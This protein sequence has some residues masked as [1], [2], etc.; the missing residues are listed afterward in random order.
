MTVCSASRTEAV[1]GHRVHS[2]QCPV[3]AGRAS[4]SS[5]SGT[6]SA[7]PLRRVPS[8]HLDP[9]LEAELALGDDLSPLAGP[10]RSARR[11]HRPFRPFPPSASSPSNRPARPRRIR[12]P[13]PAARRW[14]GT[15]MPSFTVRT[16]RRTLTNS[17]GQSL[18]SAFG[19]SALSL[20]VAVVV[21]IE[22]SMTLSSPS[23]IGVESM[24]DSAVTLSGVASASRTLAMSCCGRLKI[25]LSGLGLGQHDDGAAVRLQRLPTSTWRIPA[26]PSIGAMIFVKLNCVRALLT[27]AASPAIRA[28]C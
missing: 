14:P 6:G 22:L 16:A 8:R 3:A 25:T 13:A 10:A 26:R 9:G 7:R 27:A 12:H 24:R 11:R 4:A 1:A 21:S 28:S 19:N 5:P 20:N 2:P 23:A 15:T 18:R 17:P